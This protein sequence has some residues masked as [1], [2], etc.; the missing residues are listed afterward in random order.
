M[1]NACIYSVFCGLQVQFSLDQSMAGNEAQT[2][3]KDFKLE[4]PRKR[5]VDVSVIVEGFGINCEHN[6]YSSF[7]CIDVTST[8][9]QEAGHGQQ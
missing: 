1:H 9:K 4:F 8:T 3:L 6:F 5:K 2:I 7:M